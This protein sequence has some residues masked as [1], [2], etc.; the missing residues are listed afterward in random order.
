ML[1]ISPP[2]LSGSSYRKLRI[3]LLGGSFNPAHEGHLH[4]SQLA[5]KNMKLDAV[6]WLVSPQNP[7]K[8]D[9]GMASFAQRFEGAKLLTRDCP[10]IIVSDMEGKLGTR[11][12]ADTL[13]QLTRR[14]PRTRFIWMMGADN[15]IQIP[16]WQRW[17]EI[18][19]LCDV[20]VYRRPPYAVGVLRGKAAQRFYK[21]R[22]PPSK[23]KQLGT[24]N[25]TTSTSKKW[26]LFSNRLNSES[27]T[28]IRN[29]TKGK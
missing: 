19:K 5:L 2:L 25:F 16:R 28:Q 23:A 4:I 11:F 12:T 29:R 24:H 13:K 10:N 26:I 20:A 1:P 17:H 27:A 9:K 18:F 7:L 15:L 8:S 3:G 21:N 6:W 14:F 22:I